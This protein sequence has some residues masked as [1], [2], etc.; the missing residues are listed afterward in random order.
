MKYKIIKAI[1]SQDYIEI[2]YEVVPM[3]AV[4]FLPITIKAFQT[5]VNLKGFRVWEIE[6]V[7]NGEIHVRSGLMDWQ[8]FY[9]SVRMNEALVI[10]LTENVRRSNAQNTST[11]N[12]GKVSA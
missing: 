12:A 7:I 1:I 3:R 10:F 9:E 6:T 5:F 11:D 8:E 4:K 2:H